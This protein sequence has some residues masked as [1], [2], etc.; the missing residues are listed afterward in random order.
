MIFVLSSV[1]ASFF[2]RL[3]WLWQ[4]SA[5]SSLACSLSP[6]PRQVLPLRKLLGCGNFP[7]QCVLKTIW[8]TKKSR[9]WEFSVHTNWLPKLSGIGGLLRMKWEFSVKVKNTDQPIA[10]WAPC[11][12]HYLRGLS[13]ISISI[14]QGSSFTS[15]V[16][17][18]AV[19]SES[20][21]VGKSLKKR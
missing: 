5:A 19:E 3:T 14:R 13:S 12:L 8:L 20:L 18:R 17:I 6:S 1:L 9:N 4:L 15:R 7:H 16:N 10:K 21:K 11:V 2:P